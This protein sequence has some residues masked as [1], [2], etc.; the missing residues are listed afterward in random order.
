MV[1]FAGYARL[2]H[3]DLYIRA[4]LTSLGIAAVATVFCL[5]I[6]Y[7]MVLGLI[8]VSSGRRTILLMPVILPFWASFLLQVYAWM[9]LMAA[10]VAIALLALMVGP[11]MICSDYQSKAEGT[12]GRT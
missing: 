3:D 5:L 12:E 1:N 11:M 6:G 8:R 10:T 9:G 2:F 7:P 4:F